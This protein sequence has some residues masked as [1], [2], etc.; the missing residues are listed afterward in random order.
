MSD[1]MQKA[2]LPII[3]TPIVKKA[4]T[5]VGKNSAYSSSKVIPNK[6]A[7]KRM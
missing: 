7:Y 3:K 1:K 5:F 6:D 4:S 2:K